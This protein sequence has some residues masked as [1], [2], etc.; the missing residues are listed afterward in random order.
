MLKNS[1]VK[2]GLLMFCY[3][4]IKSS[5]PFRTLDVYSWQLIHVLGMKIRKKMCKIKLF[6][7]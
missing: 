7:L 6:N 1:I 3:V 2:K 4:Q 5:H